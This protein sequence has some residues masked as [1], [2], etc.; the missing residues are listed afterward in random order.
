MSAG[1]LWSSPGGDTARSSDGWQA[2]ARKYPWARRV[3]FNPLCA[4]SG[5]AP[6]PLTRHDWHTPDLHEYETLSPF[7]S[8]QSSTLSPGWTGSTRPA[9]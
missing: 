8:R 1:T 5:I 9:N 3:S 2:H 7:R 6:V 4:R